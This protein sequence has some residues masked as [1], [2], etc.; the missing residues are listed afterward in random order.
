MFDSRQDWYRDIFK[1]SIEVDVDTN[2]YNNLCDFIAS[3]DSNFEKCKNEEL[4]KCAIANDERISK[5]NEEDKIII[6]IKNNVGKNMESKQDPKNFDEVLDYYI[7]LIEECAEVSKTYLEPPIGT[8]GMKK[9]E[10]KNFLEYRT[11]LALDVIKL[12]TLN[13]FTS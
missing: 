12:S 9:E 10:L 6:E 4:T 7:S 1:R 5:M 8:H 3:Y 11:G 13:K 2:S